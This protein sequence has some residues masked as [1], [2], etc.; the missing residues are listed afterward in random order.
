MGSK[1]SHTLDTTQRHCFRSLRRFAH[2]LRASTGPIDGAYVG[3]GWPTKHVQTTPRNPRHSD[4]GEGGRNCSNLFGD[5]VQDTSSSITIAAY[6]FLC[7]SIAF[8][9]IFAP[10]LEGNGTRYRACG[11]ARASA[12]RRRW[13]RTRRAGRSGTSRR[14]TRRCC[15]STRRHWNGTVPATRR[16]SAISAFL[17]CDSE[18]F[19]YFSAY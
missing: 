12:W 18:R 14:R 16:G 3:N 4:T 2:T 1:P 6:M 13:G 7:S 9:N 11:I 15:R 8:G 17:F 19:R 10:P 5:S